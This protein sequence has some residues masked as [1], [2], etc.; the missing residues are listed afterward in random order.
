MHIAANVWNV[1]LSCALPRD[2]E[3]AE[4]LEVVLVLDWGLATEWG[5]TEIMP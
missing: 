4:D 2:R 1:I 3:E 5:L